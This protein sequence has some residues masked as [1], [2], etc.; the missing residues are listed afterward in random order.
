MMRAVLVLDTNTILHGVVLHLI[1]WKTKAKIAVAPW[2]ADKD[3]EPFP[4]DPSTSSRMHAF[5]ERLRKIEKALEGPK[6]SSPRI[7]R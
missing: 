4:P 3:E 2:N 1:D 6:P 7:V 5:D